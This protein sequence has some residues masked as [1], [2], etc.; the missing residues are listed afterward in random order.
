MSKNIK[1]KSEY[2]IDCS[3]CLRPSKNNY[4]VNII[5]AKYVLTKETNINYFIN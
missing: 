2:R 1:N 3:I 4:N 5:Y